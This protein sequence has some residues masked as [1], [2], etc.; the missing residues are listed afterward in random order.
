MFSFIGNLKFCL[1]APLGI[2]QVPLLLRITA[3]YYWANIPGFHQYQ[4]LIIKKDTEEE[5]ERERKK[6]IAYCQDFLILGKRGIFFDQ[7]DFAKK[8]RCNLSEL[9][10]K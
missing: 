7:Q 10:S 5:R 6:K 1:A 2:T 9:K 4:D 3:F 8:K